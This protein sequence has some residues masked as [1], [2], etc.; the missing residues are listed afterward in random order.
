MLFAIGMYIVKVE[1]WVFINSYFP[2]Y[3]HQSWL[4]TDFIFNKLLSPNE[5]FKLT[6]KFAVF[7]K[8]F[9]YT[10]FPLNFGICNV[11]VSLFYFCS[12]TLVYFGVERGVDCS[13]IS[14]DFLFLSIIMGFCT[15]TSFAKLMR[16]KYSIS[17]KLS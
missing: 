17:D 12:N 9:F 11:F 3:S 7:D 4:F 6:V 1:F 10:Q 5:L 13:S 15:M 16:F 8:L 14:F 2:L